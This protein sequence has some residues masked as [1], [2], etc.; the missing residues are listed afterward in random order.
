MS[1]AF[2]QKKI[3]HKR[4]VKNRTNFL[5]TCYRLNC[6]P[7][8]FILISVCKYYESL[9]YLTLL[10]V[11]YHSLSRVFKS[12]IISSANIVFILLLQLLCF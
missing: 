8:K 7:P 9:A 10:F 5:Q 2:I 4:K 3:Y 12:F 1:T 11:F 6:V